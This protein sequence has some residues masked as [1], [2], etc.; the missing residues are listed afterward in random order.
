MS[1]GTVYES[2][3]KGL[4]EA[5]ADASGKGPKLPRHTIIVEPVKQYHAEDVK[6]I[7]KSIGMSQRIFA[8]YMGVSGKT[9]EAWEAGTNCPSGSSS[10]LLSMMEMD[11]ELVVRYPFVSESV[12]K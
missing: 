6:R 12:A 11:S 4:E 9:V 3:M 10:R 1:N 7:R 5:L 2:I 8:G